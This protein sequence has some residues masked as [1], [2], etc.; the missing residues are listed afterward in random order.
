MRPLARNGCVNGQ[1]S[2][3]VD[4]VVGC[5]SRACGDVRPVPRR[6]EQD[7]HENRCERRDPREQDQQGRDRAK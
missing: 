7:Q 5:R 3:C 6:A 2:H 4:T 1:Q